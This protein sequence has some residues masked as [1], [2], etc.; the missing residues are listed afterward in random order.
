MLRMTLKY[1]QPKLKLE[2]TVQLFQMSWRMGMHFFVVLCNKSLLSNK[3]EL[4]RLE[5]FMEAFND[6]WGIRGTKMTWSWVEYGISAWYDQVLKTLLTYCL[7]MFI[8]L[9]H[10][11]TWSSNQNFQCFLM[12]QGKVTLYSICLHT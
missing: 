12:Q 8:L 3:L 4:F 5:T 9:L 10:I 6:G 1:R 2:I 7:R 11:L